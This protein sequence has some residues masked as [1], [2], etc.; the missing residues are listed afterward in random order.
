MFKKNSCLTEHTLYK[1]YVKKIISCLTEHTLY[2]TNSILGGDEIDIFQT[3]NLKWKL[4][5]NLQHEQEVQPNQVKRHSN[6][7][8]TNLYDCNTAAATYEVKTRKTTT[9]KQIRNKNKQ[10][11]TSKWKSL[12]LLLQRKP[13][14]ESIIYL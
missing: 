13:L 10:I 11:R 8:I 9:S 12:V 5:E 1:Y 4:K 7:K 14:S 3:Q 6:K 2:K